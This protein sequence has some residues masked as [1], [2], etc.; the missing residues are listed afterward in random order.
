MEVSYIRMDEEDPG[1][2]WRRATYYYT[3]DGER[4]RDVQRLADAQND[5]G[6]PAGHWQYICE[7][8]LDRNVPPVL[9][10]WKW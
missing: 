7:R 3:A 8:K 1:F 5:S 2:S 9:G 4:A 6:I 10:M